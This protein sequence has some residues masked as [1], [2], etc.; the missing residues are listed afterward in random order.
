MHNKSL[1]YRYSRDQGSPRDQFESRKHKGGI[2]RVLWLQHQSSSLRLQ[3]GVE[4]QCKITLWWNSHLLGTS[5][6]TRHFPV[7]QKCVLYWPR[8][9]FHY[10]VIRKNVFH[11]PQFYALCLLV[12]LKVK[13]KHIIFLSV[14]NCITLFLF[15][16]RTLFQCRESA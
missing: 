3:G 9:S 15:R 10:R 6:R 5:R 12:I 14:N 13:L 8:T 11:Q 1:S 16:S 7:Y 4:T 2:G